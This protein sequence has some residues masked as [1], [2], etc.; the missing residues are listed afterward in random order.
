MSENKSKVSNRAPIGGYSRPH[1][2]RYGGVTKL[3]ATGTT[4]NPESGGQ[5]DQRD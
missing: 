5:P 3:T 4:P 1:L 2:V